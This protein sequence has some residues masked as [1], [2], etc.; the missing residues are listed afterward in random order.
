MATVTVR[1]NKEEEELFY[2][3]SEFSGEKLSTLLK[4]SL[5]REIEDAYDYKKGIE[6]LEEF[7]KDPVTY[8]IDDVIKELENDV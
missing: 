4:N 8:S 3:Y 2:T 5:I 1:L 6:A 7:E